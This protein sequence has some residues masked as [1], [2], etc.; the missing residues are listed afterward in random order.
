M[1]S[2]RRIVLVA[3][4]AA[5]IGFFVPVG[6]D[7]ALAQTADELIALA[8]KIQN[9][10]PG[11]G[12]EISTERDAYAIG[13]RVTF[14]F[15]ADKDCYLSIIN[16]GTTGQT[17]IL[18]PNKSHPDNKIQKDQVYKIPAENSDFAYKVIGPP[19]TERVKVIASLEPLVG[20][21]LSLQEEL[22]VPVSQDTKPGAVFLSMKNPRVF[23]KD[24]AIEVSKMEPSKW[25]AVELKFDVRDGA[26][27]TV[28]QLPAGPDQQTGK[29]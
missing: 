22:K 21:L 19:G 9:Q 4:V 5:F 25:A 1:V 8:D 12:C 3:V 26:G 20:N 17:L 11:I 23:F 28:T 10:D 6:N 16:I 27:A 14:E 2:M 15:K 7:N 13:E 18:F 29:P 24:L